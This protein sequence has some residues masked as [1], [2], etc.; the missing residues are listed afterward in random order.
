[1]PSGT[2]GNQLAIRAQA[3]AGDQVVVEDGA[4]IY[5][6]EAGA[7][8]VLTGVQLTCV[9][10]PG[11]VLDW[12][13]VAAALNPADNVH[14]APPRLVCLENTHNRA[15]GRIL[16]QRNVQ[17]I[18]DGRPRPGPAGAPGRGPPVARPR[19]HGPVP[20]R[21]GRARG[22]RQRL[23][24]Q[25]PGRARGLGA[26]SD[27]ADHHRGPPLA[28]AAGRGHAPGG[29]PGRGLPTTPWTIIWRGWPRTT[30]RRGA[31]PRGWT[32]PHLAVNHPVDTNIVIIDV[33]GPDG[34]GALLRH[35]E[36]AGVLGV[37]FGPGRVRLI[38]N[39][40]T[41]AAAVDAALAALNAFPGAGG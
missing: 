17:A 7:P 37:S 18:A 13:L 22:Q 26:G 1:M 21:A 24:Q 35:L 8:A 4:H 40:D 15:G 34:D 5:R 27:R 25:G 2:M 32:I 23:L 29:C 16:P 10:A 39:L 14:C 12:P 33:A 30:P 38:P 19:G 31:W 3:R 6:Y 36:L 28:Q 11:G 20:G 9:A 41:S